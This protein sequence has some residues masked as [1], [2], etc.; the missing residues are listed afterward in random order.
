MANTAKSLESDMKPHESN[1]DVWRQETA[2]EL[3]GEW[4][5]AILEL[6]PATL[7]RKETIVAFAIATTIKKF[8]AR[9]VQAL[10]PAIDALFVG[11]DALTANDRAKRI[12][13]QA[14]VDGDVCLIGDSI[15]LHLKNTSFGKS[16]LSVDKAFA[17]LATKK[18]SA[19]NQCMEK[20]PPAPKPIP[21][22][23][24]EKFR[25][26]VALGIVTQAEYDGCLEPAAPAGEVAVKIPVEIE[27]A[28]ARMLLAAP[29]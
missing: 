2:R 12:D 6:E 18:P 28:L 24:A 5:A 10:R 16:V 17:V 25:G 19:K 8:I 21:R 29:R 27:E 23:S 20:P 26:L 9:R 7:T 22:F 3:V 11:D 15:E 14:I 4:R 13:E 1:G